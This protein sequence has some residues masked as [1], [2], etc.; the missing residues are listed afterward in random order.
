MKHQYTLDEIKLKV[1]KLLLELDSRKIR[2]EELKKNNLELKNSIENQKNTIIRLEERNKIVK[3]AESLSNSKNDI[4]ELK[5]KV[6]E[7]INEIDECI[8]LLSDR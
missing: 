8:R 2:E 3:L 6:N 7:Y 1:A 5:K 4:Q